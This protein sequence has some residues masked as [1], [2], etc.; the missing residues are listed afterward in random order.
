[1]AM[2]SR[3]AGVMIKL[4]ESCELPIT[5]LESAFGNITN[6]YKFYWFLA[7]IECV[8]STENRILSVDEL[9]AQMI[10]SVWYPIHYYRLSLGKQDR[11]GLIVSRLGNEDRSLEI[12][13]KQSAIV[14]SVLEQI[15]LRSRL[16]REIRSLGDYVP[17][18]FLRPFFQN[19]LRG[20]ADSL[21]NRLIEEMADSAFHD[22]TSPCLYRFVD[23]AVRY[24]EL[25]PVWLEYLKTHINI[26]TGFC[27]W[28]LVS[29]VQKQN[30][31][32]PNVPGKLFQPEQRDLRAAR[33]YWSLAI[34]RLQEV[35]CI[36]SNRPVTVNDFSLDHFLPW[37]FVGH[38]LLWN[39]VPTT[40]CVNSAKGDQLPDMSV[41]FDPFARIQYAALRA[42][43]QLGRT[44]H[45]ED[46]V[47]L[48]RADVSQQLQH[49]PFE[50]F[51]QVLFDTISPQIQIAR[52]M[53]FGDNWTYGCTSG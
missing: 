41:Y 25:Q 49:I 9:L 5:A 28:H 13:A 39:I 2:F 20:T 47:M 42:V 35:R 30:P 37:R 21:V 40:K 45:L 10:A 43:A 38:D 29:Y 52:N 27:L 51:R 44:K 4:P 31:N 36:Y 53:G 24:I 15:S 18:R 48:L 11:L 22:K 26:L 34:Q 8:K 1:M 32:V 33:A 19:Q 3:G 12:N 50:T 6:S 7:I 23:R 16:G 14:A 46:F 17:Q